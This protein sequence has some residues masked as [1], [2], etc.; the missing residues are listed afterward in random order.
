[1]RGILYRIAAIL[2]SVLTLASCGSLGSRSKSPSHY[3]RV[4]IV[5]S[6]GHNSLSSLL[7]ANID[8]ISTNYLPDISQKEAVV[9]IAQNYRTPE[10]SVIQMYRHKGR[11]RT[12]TL[13]TFAAGRSMAQADVLR[14]ALE[15]VERRF[16]SDHYRMVVSSHGSDW[17]PAGVSPFRP[18]SKSVT[19]GDHTVD[20]HYTTYEIGIDEFYRALPMHFDCILF[21]M[22]LMGGVEVAHELRDRADYLAFST[23]EVLAEGFDYGKL[24]RD[25]L[26]QSDVERGVRDVCQHFY[27]QYQREGAIKSATVSI[28]K[29]S[30]MDRL[31]LTCKSLF[32]KYRDGLNHPTEQPQYYDGARTIH[33]CYDLKDVLRVSGVSSSDAA[34]LQADL[35]R[36]VIYKLATDS[37]YSAG[38]PSYLPIKHYCGLSMYMPYYGST[39]LSDYYRTL[40]WNEATGLVQ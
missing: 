38:E 20:G 29:S 22:C 34:L 15:V 40:S 5:Y 37:R 33:W 23:A 24:T 21:D 9:T 3:D 8:S 11:L 26:T 17:L 28:V 39:T 30:E 1:M 12:D 32:E 16:D 2:L 27:D 6:A 18:P 10:A 36:A 14:E 25:L 31:A 19:A 4:L 35:D 7:I 13:M